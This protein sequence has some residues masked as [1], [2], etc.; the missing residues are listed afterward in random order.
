MS[1]DRSA[2]SGAPDGIVCFAGQDWWYH[3]RA[4]SEVQ[5]MLRLARDR[6]VLLVNSIG[7]RMPM[8]GRSTQPARRIARKLHSFTRGLQA[9]VP[10]LPNFHVL[11]PVTVPLGDARVRA[12]NTSSIRAQVRRAM[13]RIG[14][15]RP[16]MF[17]TVPTAWEVVESMPRTTL[18]YNRADRHSA[19]DEADSE[20]IGGLE[21]ELLRRADHVLYVS[22]A[23]MDEERAETG[24]RAAFLD[25][26]VD[27]ELFR[28]DPSAPEPPELAVIPHPRIGYF[29]G[30]EPLTVDFTLL[31]GL[32]RDLPD[33]QLVL[34]GNATVPLD[35]LLARP[36]VHFLGMQ[37]Y[38]AVPSYGR[39]FDVGIMPWLQN[40]WIEAC[41]PIKLKEYLAL[42]LPIVSIDF[43]ELER[44]HPLVTAVDD[45]GEF[46]AAVAEVLASGGPSSAAA[47]R[48]SVEPDSWDSKAELLADLVG[49]GRRASWS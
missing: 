49:L 28:P 27:L 13:R 6:P 33:A 12:L 11:S 46:T 37:P 43:P 2:A 41:N 39:G 42:G 22:H 17:V 8:P 23:L 38:E 9:P 30:L 14:I 7:M 36:N 47:R 20:L 15:A 10:D 4:H 1:S 3:S 24:D 18:V 40:D 16:V 34:V 21:R 26:G 48:E 32:A 44:Y 19:F 35:S 5:L 45:P 25:H 29:G 31:E